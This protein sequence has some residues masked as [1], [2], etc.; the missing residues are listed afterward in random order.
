[1]RKEEMLGVVT[2]TPLQIAGKPPSQAWFLQK[3]INN[4]EANNLQRPY[5]SSH[6]QW[7]RDV[8]NG[9]NL[10]V[11]NSRQKGGAS[12]SGIVVEQDFIDS[13]TGGASQMAT[14]SLTYVRTTQAQ[15]QGSTTKTSTTA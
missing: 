3:Q 13:S 6:L 2:P 7:R 14:R 15:S 8:N 5:Q 10:C 9:K 12:C 1:M 11:S 4:K